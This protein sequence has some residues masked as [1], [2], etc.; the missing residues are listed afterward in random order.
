MNYA[1]RNVRGAVTVVP[2][3]T[4][5]SAQ[6]VARAAVAVNP[7]Q[8][9]RAPVSARVAV[10]PTQQSVLG[11]KAST[12]NHVTA[13]PAA[14]M[15]RQVIAKR[16]PPPPPVP[17]AKQQQA[18]AAHPGQPL[19]QHE[20]Q[21]LRPTAAAAAHPMVK[22]GASRQTGDA[23]HGPSRQPAQ[24]WPPGTAHSAARYQPANRPPRQR[25]AE[26]TPGAA[27]LRRT[28]RRQ[29]NR[30]IVP[31]R[32]LRRTV[33]RQRNRRIIQR[34]LPRRTVRRQHSRRI[35]QPRLPRIESSTGSTTAESSSA[36]S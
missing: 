24:C 11:A 35:V 5:A 4:F 10:A 3:R 23:D 14:V 27:Q 28:V 30:R 9:A 25:S 8:I 15:N 6:P 31:R 21:N 1:N 36:A 19:A 17:F 26:S 2:Q 22:V 20:I 29:H 13:P 12:A 18:L 16:T 34:R 7:Q 32:L 33:R